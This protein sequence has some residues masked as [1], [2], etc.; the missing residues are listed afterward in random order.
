MRIG[1]KWFVALTIL[2]L[3]SACG[4][5]IDDKVELV[6]I[7]QLHSIN[8][9]GQEI[10]DGKGYLDF[11]KNG[12]VFSRTGP[13]LYDEGKY[14]IDPSKSLI[15]MKQDTTSQSY[16]YTMTKDSLAMKSNENGLALLL[17]GHKVEKLPVT[18]DNDP[19]PEGMQ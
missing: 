6:G 7:W 14:E 10:G 16:T 12:T 17:R 2:A 5:K 19:M 1:T 13:N 8:V 3:L 18:P 15:V 9:N 11:Q 4:S